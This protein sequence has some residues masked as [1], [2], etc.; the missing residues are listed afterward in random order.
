MDPGS[1]VSQAPTLNGILQEAL[2][3]QYPTSAFSDK[4]HSESASFPPA[5][6]CKPLVPSGFSAVSQV[7]ESHSKDARIPR[8]D[9]HASQLFVAGARLPL[10]QSVAMFLFP[11][12]LLML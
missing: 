10:R 12:R 7:V 5:S 2:S 1:R 11:P 4:S 3:T 6:V 9:L 8:L